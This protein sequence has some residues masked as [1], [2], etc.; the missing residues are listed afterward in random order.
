MSITTQLIPVAPSRW[1]KSRE[2]TLLRGSHPPFSRHILHRFPQRCG[3]SVLHLHRDPPQAVNLLH[4]VERAGQ[5][6]RAINDEGEVV[7]IEAATILGQPAGVVDAVV[8]K[9]ILC[10]SAAAREP[11]PTWPTTAGRS[12]CRKSCL[13][14]I[15]LRPFQHQLSTS[16]S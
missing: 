1:S 10:V 16:C 14:A 11:A 6:L 2:E 7:S 3:E 13:P 4:E 9:L 5:L 12:P 8:G 15:G